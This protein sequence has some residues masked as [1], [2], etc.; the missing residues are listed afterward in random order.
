MLKGLLPTNHCEDILNGMRA[1]HARIIPN[2]HLLNEY[3]EAGDPEAFN[4]GKTKFISVEEGWKVLIDTFVRLRMAGDDSGRHQPINLVGH[5]VENLLE[6]IKVSFGID[7]KGLRTIV[8]II[9]TQNLT[10]GALIHSPKSPN[11]SPSDLLE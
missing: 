11:I 5:A 4:F 10:K 1:A 3:T 9:D 8:K 7:L 2:V 6:H